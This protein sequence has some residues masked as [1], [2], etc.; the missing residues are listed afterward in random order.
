MALQLAQATLLYK[1]TGKT[2]LFLFDDL[3]A[4]LDAGNQARVMKLLHAISAQ[5]FVTSINHV[6]LTDWPVEQIKRFHVEHGEVTEM[7]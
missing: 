5:V 7:L 2:S 1:E 3:G 4:E 6:E